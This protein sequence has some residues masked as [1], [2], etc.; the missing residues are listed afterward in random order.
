LKDALVEFARFARS[1]RGDEKGEAQPFLHH[2]LPRAR[3]Q[4]V[5]EAVA[6]FEFRV[7]K[8]PGSPQ[9]E[10][11]KGTAL[12]RARKV[13]RSLLIFSGPTAC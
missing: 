1:I 3:S 4:R 12:R 7:A 11:I 5:I 8:K 6:T 9:L 13:E 2:L 10:L